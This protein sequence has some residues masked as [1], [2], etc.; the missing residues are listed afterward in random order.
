VAALDEKD[1]RPTAVA[2]FADRPLGPGLPKVFKLVFGSAN[3]YFIKNWVDI[4]KPGTIQ[5]ST[6]PPG[7]EPADPWAVPL[8]ADRRANAE[9]HA[10]MTGP[11]DR[12]TG[13]NV[14]WAYAAGGPGGNHLLEGHKA[15]VISAAWSADGKTAA[16]GDAD[17]VVI[18][19][20]G[21]TF[22]EKTRAKLAG[23]VAAL[24]LTADGKRVAAAVIELPTAQDRPSYHERVFV[25]D[26]GRTPKDPPAL[27]VANDQPFGGPF[28]GTA[29]LA[30]SPDGKEL[31]AGFC[32]T[33]HLLR[34]GKLIGRVHVWAL[35]A[36]R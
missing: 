2:W 15:T 33:A 4:E 7:K 12:E 1:S 23:R 9:A 6:V 20:D 14:L 19:W 32:N 28:Q 22:R 25:W 35:A 5:T 31:A 21:D 34:T 27:P 36:G 30:F 26:A 24:A 17:G 13:K 3:G 10:I 16:T 18:L 29:G 11:I 8:A